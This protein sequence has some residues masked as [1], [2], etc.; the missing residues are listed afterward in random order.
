ME[1]DRS[2][3]RESARSCVDLESVV[4]FFEKKIAEDNEAL[5]QRYI[6]RMRTEPYDP[7]GLVIVMRYDCVF[8]CGHCFFYSNLHSKEILSDEAIDRAIDFAAKSGMSFVL[9]SGGE[10]MIDPQRVFRAIV[11]VK[12]KGLHALLQSSY[13]G[14]TVDQIEENATRIGKLGIAEFLTSLSVFHQHAKPPSTVMDYVDNVVRIVDA[15]TR[16]GIGV[17]I[18]NTWDVN[19]GR[20]ESVEQSNRFTQKL[21]EAGAVFLGQP[22]QQGEYIFSMNERQ[23]HLEDPCIISVGNARAQGMVSQR[24]VAWEK[25][26]YH[27]PIFYEL[28]HAGG[29]LTIY[30]DGNVARCCSAEKKANFGFGNVLTDSFEDIIRNIRR[31]DYVRPDMAVVLQEGYRM[32]HEE[33]PDLLPKDGPCQACEICSPIVAHEKTR[34]RLAERT[35]NRHL[36]V[37]YTHRN[38]R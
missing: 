13:L 6:A 17:G 16:K 8:A 38:N 33:F 25:S 21:R 29:M 18:K 12:E 11:R 4:S 9:F 14:D 20:T 28:H 22:F 5:R 3:V 35:G 7:K 26:L 1:S 36:F 19:V 2:G 32:L 23:I 30:P 27:C 37:P 10:P 24:P 34:T 15:I 31:S